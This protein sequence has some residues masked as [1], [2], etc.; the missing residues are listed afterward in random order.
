MDGGRAVMF[1]D[2]V[3]AVE[4]LAAAGVPA[5]LLCSSTRVLLVREFC[6]RYALPPE[7]RVGRRLGPGAQEVRAACVGGRRRRLRRS[8]GWSSSSATPGATPT[9]PGPQARGS[10]ACSAQDTPT[11]SPAAARTSWAR[12][13]SW[14]P[15]SSKP[16]APRP[17]HGRRASGIRCRPPGRARAVSVRGRGPRGGRS[18]SS[19]PA[20]A[21]QRPALRW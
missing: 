17:R 10:S 14:P 13:P 1:T 7:V 4:R 3:P 15:T 18:R 8:R 9:W 19:A 2:V 5:G 16:S 21:P 6:E 11:P 12:C 20:S